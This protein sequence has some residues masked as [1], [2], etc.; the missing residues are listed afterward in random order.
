MGLALAGGEATGLQREHFVIAAVEPPLALVHQRRF[1]AAI[2][3]AGHIEVT[4]GCIAL[5]C[6]LALA[7]AVMLSLTPVAG[8]GRIPEMCGQLCCQRTLDHP[9]GQQ[10]ESAMLSQA[11]LR[12]GII[13]QQFVQEGVGFLVAPG[14]LCLLAF[15]IR[16]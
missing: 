9:L 16:E 8:M 13:V 4:L 14:H 1:A 15:A 10:P 7:S 3:V 2:A 6:L 11:I 12:I 5:D